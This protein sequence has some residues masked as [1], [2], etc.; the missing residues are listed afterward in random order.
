MKS[1]DFCFIFNEKK[2]N[3]FQKSRFLNKIIKNFHFHEHPWT[4]MSIREC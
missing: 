3:F 4:F 1:S 2:L